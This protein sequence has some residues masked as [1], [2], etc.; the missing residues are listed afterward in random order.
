VKIYGKKNSLYASCRSN[1][2]LMNKML[3]YNDSAVKQY[4]EA[5]QVLSS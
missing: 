5:L 1:L 3:G 4:T 2:A